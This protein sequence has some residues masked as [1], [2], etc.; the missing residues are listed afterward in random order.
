MAEL[1]VLEFEGFDKDAYKKVNELLGIDMTTGE[2]DWPPGLLS[3]AAGR[4]EN[5]WTVVEVWESREAQE[6][7]MNGRLGPALGKA[8]VTKPPKKAEWTKL[9]AH[10]QPKQRAGAAS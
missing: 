10:H 9:R 6:K 8:G 3:H 5:G 2:G 4:I 1:F 7:F